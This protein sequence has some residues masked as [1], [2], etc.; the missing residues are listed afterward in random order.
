MSNYD[1]FAMTINAIIRK[2]LDIDRNRS[3]CFGVSSRL[4]ALVREFE[5][6]SK[7][8]LLSESQNHYWGKIRKNERNYL[9][10]D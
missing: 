8:L 6:P 10:L 4:G 1:W 5:S 9:L 7:I 2:M 3:T